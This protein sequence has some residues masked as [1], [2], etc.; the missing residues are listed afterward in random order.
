MRARPDGTLAKEFIPAV[1]EISAGFQKVYPYIAEAKPLPSEV[2]ILFSKSSIHLASKSGDFNILEV[3]S[4]SHTGAFTSLWDNCVQAD[5]V[6]EEE[7]RKGILCN[8]KVLLAPF[9]YVIDQ[10]IADALKKFVAEGG[11][12]LWDAES[13]SYDEE[14][15]YFKVPAAGLDQVMHYQAHMPYY[16][17]KPQLTLNEDYGSLRKGTV[18]SG[19][20]WWEEIETHLGGKA[21]ASFADGEPAI[22]LGRYGKGITMHVATDIFRAYFL[23]KSSET[24]E[25]VHNFLVKAGVKRPISLANIGVA[26]KGRLEATFLGSEDSTVLFLLNFNSVEVRPSVSLNLEEKECEL[27]ELITGRKILSKN[28]D[29]KTVFEVSINPYDVRVILATSKMA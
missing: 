29:S 18:L 10:G 3:P 13:G 24:K 5:F 23:E 20:K 6:D 28:E 14:M 2:A 9:L 17:E 7:V 12:L 25:F 11:H 15:Y 4:Q 1:K 22:V 19:Y 8:Y 21:I 16:D 27:K 26:E